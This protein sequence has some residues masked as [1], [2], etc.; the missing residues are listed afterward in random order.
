MSEPREPTLLELEREDPFAPHDLG[1]RCYPH[2]SQ[3]AAIEAATQAATAEYR[4]A[5]RSTGSS[6]TAEGLLNAAAFMLDLVYEVYG[7]DHEP[8]PDNLNDAGP[9]EAEGE[10]RKHRDVIRAALQA[11]S[12]SS[13]TWPGWHCACGED[14]VH[15]DTLAG[16]AESSDK[17]GLPTTPADLLDVL[18]AIVREELR[19]RASD[20]AISTTVTWVD[21][22]DLAQRLI[23][24]GFVLVGDPQSSY[25]SRYEPCERTHKTGT[26]HYH[27]S[28]VKRWLDEHPSNDTSETTDERDRLP[29][30]SHGQCF[31][32]PWTCPDPPAHCGCG[33][34]GKHVPSVDCTKPSSDTSESGDIAEAYGAGHRDGMETHDDVGYCQH[35]GREYARA[36]SP[37]QGA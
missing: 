35:D 25:T 28:H 37:R 20:D 15:D 3:R 12:E 1:C 23:K 34:V 18:T 7:T 8:D 17:S 36:S 6:A 24:R 26:T 10:F 31:A 21:A 5:R 16:R 22:R 19:P 14:V 11:A 2:V 9:W 30:E 33:N 32:A 27:P 4:A 13:D 29:S